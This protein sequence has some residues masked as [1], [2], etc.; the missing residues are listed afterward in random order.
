[1]SWDTG[2]VAMVLVLVVASIA[3]MSSFDKRTRAEASRRSALRRAADMLKDTTAGAYVLMWNEAEVLKACSWITREDL[4]RRQR[5][6]VAYAFA[7]AAMLE[8]QVRAEENLSRGM[9]AR[10][11]RPTSKEERQSEH[12]LME[13]LTGRKQGEGDWMVRPDEVDQ[14]LRAFV[15]KRINATIARASAAA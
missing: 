11:A 7:L 1:M 3:G 13:A 8:M 14:V 5:E 10:R 9:A 2:V 4:A 12:R 6:T 15:A